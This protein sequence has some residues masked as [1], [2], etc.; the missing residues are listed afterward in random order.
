[1]KINSL[2]KYLIRFAFLQILIT[3]VTIWY[4][5]NFLL[6]SNAD[7]FQ[8]YLSLVD[9]R[10]RFLTFIPLNL[11]TV[12]AVLALIIFL[13]L[14][15][16]YSTNFYNYVNELDYSYEKK[17]LDEYL[18]IYLLWTSFFFSSFLIFRFSGLS[19][20]YLILFTFLVPLILLL[21]RNSELIS[22]LL[23]RAIINENFVTFN[24]EDDSIF[25]NLRIMSFRNNLGSFKFDKRSPSKIIEIID[26]LNK[27][28][29]VNLVVINLDKS[30][31]IPLKLEKY[32]VN[33]NKKVLII[34]KEEFLFNNTFI[35]REEILDQHRLI[36]FNN[37][38]QY[39]AKY[40][41]K[42]LIDI[43]LGTLALV[44]FTPFMLLIS[45]FIFFKDGGP[46]II[47]QNRVGLHGQI[48]KMYKFRTMYQHSHA[49]REDLQELNTKSGP[50]FKIDN[51]PRLIPGAV[52][53]RKYS[54]DELPQIINVLLGRMSLVGPRPLFDSDTK[55]FDSNYMRRLNVM[56]GMTGL[57][58]VNDRNANDFETWFKYDV[59]YIEN[60]SLYLDIK[61]ILK[62]IPSLFIRNI[63]GK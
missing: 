25:H 31:S 18:N 37:D 29:N 56:P 53:L 47:K 26:G 9:D 62:T 52:F 30:K 60:W 57:L 58:Q 50:L 17:Y 11:I 51:D 49:L 35:Y 23:G 12:D 41:L 21:F 59:E 22:G 2:L 3:T 10:N 16:L 42:R 54:L 43:I 46:V 28:I 7:K 27:T 24:L 1:M 5:D 32:L 34:T 8:L 19:R 55:F 13:F 39:G 36:Y 14:I 38:I 63:Q 45:I 44:I 4:F 6:F 61:I 15:L 48:F 20:G 40:V 33:I